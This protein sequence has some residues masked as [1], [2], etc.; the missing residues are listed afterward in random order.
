M[1]AVKAGPDGS[2]EH[3]ATR[4]SPGNRLQKMRELADA[5]AD[6]E[7]AEPPRPSLWEINAQLYGDDGLAK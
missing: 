2:D 7:R 4:C 1:T 6:L 5:F 3:G